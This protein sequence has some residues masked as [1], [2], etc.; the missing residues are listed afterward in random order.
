MVELYTALVQCDPFKTEA[1]KQSLLQQRPEEF[2]QS[3]QSALRVLL[4]EF[5]TSAEKKAVGNLPLVELHGENYQLSSAFE[6]LLNNNELFAEFVDDYLK[7]ALFLAQ[8]K[9]S[10]DGKLIVG[11]RYS[12]RDALRLLNWQAMEVAQ[13]IVV[14]RLTRLLVLV[15]SL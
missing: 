11:Q 10:W 3:I 13:N 8:H 6:S 12:R 15:R 14:T 9:Y 7:T 4:L 1:E 2:H 5:A